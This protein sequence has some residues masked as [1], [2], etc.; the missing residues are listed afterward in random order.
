VIDTS[1]Q[2]TLININVLNY[3][4]E[5]WCPVDPGVFS[6]A[7]LVKLQGAAA[8]VVKF[9]DNAALRFAGL[10]LTQARGDNLTRDIEAQLR[11]TFGPWCARR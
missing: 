3:V 5:V 11:T 8:E 10:V 6:L 1:P 7:G 9:L 2:R 4:A